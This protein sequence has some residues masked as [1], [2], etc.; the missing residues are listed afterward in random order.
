MTS[1]MSTENTVTLSLAEAETLSQLILSEAGLSADHVAAMTR[2][3]LKGQADE[4]HSHGLYRLIGCVK[5]VRAGKVRPDA[6]PVVDDV[7]PAL[8]RVDAGYGFSPLAFEQGL[9]V[10]VQKAKACGMA[11]MVINDCCHFSALWPEVEAL[12]ESELAGLAMTPSHAW[13]APF[14][15]SEGLLGTNPIAF[16]WPRK[17]RQPYVFDFATSSMARGDIE[18]HAKAGTPIA[19]GAA[20]DREGKPTSDPHA[21]LNGAMLPFGGHKGSALSTM[22]EIMAGA[23]IGDRLSAGSLA[24][25]DGAKALPVHGELI[26]AFDPGLFGGVRS[27]TGCKAAEDL[28]GAFANQ[29]ARLPSGRRYLARQKSQNHGIQISRP[30]HQ[31]LQSLVGEL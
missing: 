4:C 27:A 9:P 13:V 28:F 22:V 1:T 20:V 19:A 2:V 24:Y 11:A 17:G 23:L 25:D 26:M 6:V 18:L 16:A 29:G 31:E 30:L 10:L 15:G 8:L 3:I 14:G 7:T 5:S 21:A 12:A